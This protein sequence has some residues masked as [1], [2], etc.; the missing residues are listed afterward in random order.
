MLPVISRGVR[1]TVAL[2]LPPLAAR[3]GD[4]AP[5]EPLPPHTPPPAVE[6][7]PGADRGVHQRRRRGGRP[8]ERDVA[9][10]HPG[11]SARRQS[12]GASA[13]GPAR[14]GYRPSAA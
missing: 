13:S 3:A 12:S 7:A 2:M 9:V 10:G 8:D 4:R 11:A 14:V 1:C 6:D 5:T